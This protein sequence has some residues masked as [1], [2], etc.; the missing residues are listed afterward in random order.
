MVRRY[1]SNGYRCRLEAREQVSVTLQ[2]L[3]EV[4]VVQSGLALLA[5][6]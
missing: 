5:A 3:S 4:V 6:S 1:R 2:L